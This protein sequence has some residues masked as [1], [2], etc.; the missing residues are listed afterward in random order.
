MSPSGES[1]RST[2]APSGRSA[3]SLER[4]QRVLV[5]VPW[6]LEH[7]G[8][9]IQTIAQRFGTTPDE[10]LADLDVLGY[11]GLP[12]YGGGDLIEVAV[13]ADEVVVRMADFFR[14]PLRL[15]LREAVT[16]L[17]AA[18]AFEYLEGTGRSAVLE[19]AVRKIAE[20]VGGGAW[21]EQARFAVDLDAPGSEL[22]AEARRAV[23]EQRVVRLVYRS[24]SRAETTER[25]VEP[26]AVVA[27]QGSWYLQGYCRLVRAP[28]D[29]RLDRVRSL[30]VTEQPA[31]PGTPPA[32]PVYRPGPDDIE[33]VLDLD[34][35]AWWLVEW[36]VV[37]AVEDHDGRRRVRLRT[38]DVDWAARLV[39]QLSPHAQPVS[40]PLLA[41]RV[42]RLADAA[43]ARYRPR[44][45]KPGLKA[46]QRPAEQHREANER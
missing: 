23:D 8:A 5:M 38:R 9:S 16:L 35:P 3:R 4:L 42:A 41:E 12:G 7:P 11:C 20:A 18:R 19:S 40:P 13:T 26:W 14:R 29:F 36:A 31:A 17:L 10:V 30:T 39:L 45:S 25:D 34:P 22:V 33:V 32:P 46:E 24:A 44:P 37:D 2:R 27:A 6:L 28:R 43:L 15:S 21:L 1:A